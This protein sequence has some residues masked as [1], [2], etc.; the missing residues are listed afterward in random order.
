MKM[1]KESPHSPY[2]YKERKRPRGSYP[3]E[4]TMGIYETGQDFKCPVTDEDWGEYFQENKKFYIPERV[5]YPDSW[6]KLHE[7]GV[8]NPDDLKHVL[9]LSPNG[10]GML[11]EQQSG[12]IHPNQL[13]SKRGRVCQHCGISTDDAFKKWPGMVLK[14]VGHH[15]DETNNKEIEWVCRNCHAC[16]W[17]LGVNIG[18]YSFPQ[19][20]FHDVLNNPK[21]GVLTLTNIVRELRSHQKKGNP[22][23]TKQTVQSKFYTLGLH[24]FYD[25]RHIPVPDY[26]KK[27]FR[28]EH[29]KTFFTFN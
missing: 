23:M 10:H 2:D 17:D 5:H 21:D 27:Y 3:Y 18:K 11:H 16:T 6:A 8:E 25:Y 13:D 15:Y 1:K 22:K 9:F 4:I 28:N 12:I 24:R 19:E 20:L 29:A 7:M 26:I 14:M